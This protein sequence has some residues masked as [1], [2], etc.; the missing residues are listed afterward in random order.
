MGK[1]GVLVVSNPGL[2][3]KLK[4]LAFCIVYLDIDLFTG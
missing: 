1:Y 3:T 2:N 4:F